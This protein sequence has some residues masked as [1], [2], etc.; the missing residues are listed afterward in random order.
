MDTTQIPYDISHDDKGRVHV[1]QMTDRQLLEEIATNMRSTVDTVQS[2][3]KSMETN[4]MMATMARMFG[5]K[6]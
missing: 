6:K 4:P 5:G 1:G 3:V 2:F